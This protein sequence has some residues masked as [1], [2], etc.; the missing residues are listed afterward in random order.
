VVELAEENVCAGSFE[1][2][3]ELAGSTTS[4]RLYRRMDTVA[5][6]R[7]RAHLPSV[8]FGYPLEHLFQAACYFLLEHTSL[9]TGH[10]AK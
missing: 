3:N 5:L 6:D 8:L 10:C 4:I 2:V 9:G 7:Q 1:S